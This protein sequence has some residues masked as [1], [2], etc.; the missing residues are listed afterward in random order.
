MTR[1]LASIQRVTEVNPIEGADRIEQVKVLGWSLV[2]KKGEFK[3]GDDAV[4]FEIDAVLPDEPWARFMRERKFRV[5]TVKMRGCLSQGLALPLSILPF[6]P[7]ECSIGLDVTEPLHVRKYEPPETGGVNGFVYGAPM[8]LFVPRTDEW[9]VQSA[10]ELLEEIKQFDFYWTVKLDGISA[11]Y[12]RTDRDYGLW[13]KGDLIVCN[14]KVAT[15]EDPDDQGAFWPMARKYDLANRIPIGMA[16]QGEIMGPKICGNKLNLE[17]HDLFIF[18]VYDLIESRFLD[19]EEMLA[20]CQNRELKTVPLDGIFFDAD[21]ALEPPRGGMVACLL[22]DYRFRQVIPVR[23]PMRDTI[24][25]EWFLNLAQGNY[26][27]TQNRREGIVVRPIASCV[28]SPTLQ[29]LINLETE[30][31]R[32][33]FKVLNNNFLLKDET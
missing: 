24:D 29:G 27:G 8:P 20:F 14:R 18:S 23:P 17:E 30:S 26:A 12:I 28:D 25:M 11:T 33:T 31:P 10:P 22:R 13:K 15:R 1:K 16:V 2:A 9:R 32:L 21:E 4:F 19:L 7:E 3:P 5:K 6:P